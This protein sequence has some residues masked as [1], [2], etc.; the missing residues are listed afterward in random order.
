MRNTAVGLNGGIF[1]VKIFEFWWKMNYLVFL[2]RMW[3][4]SN[5]IFKNMLELNWNLADEN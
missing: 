3:Y 2:Y 1:F 4:S 5:V